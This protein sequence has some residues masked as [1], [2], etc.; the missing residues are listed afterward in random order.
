MHA[1]SGTSLA[2][3][4]GRVPLQEGLSCLSTQ[5]WVQ[6]DLKELGVAIGQEVTVRYR[7]GSIPGTSPESPQRINVIVYSKG[8]KVAWM[9]F[10][11]KKV[12][13]QITA[14]DNA[15]R[16]TLDSRGWSASEGNGG[17]ATYQA[18]SRFAT[19]L[20]KEPTYQIVLQ[21]DGSS[22]AELESR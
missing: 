9:F 4:G 18:I 12:N 14:I 22:C 3:D 17:I 11:N 13:N 5:S 7:Q 16:L 8:Q 20:S 2:C 19:K 6:D 1:V 10:F 15:Y 21:S